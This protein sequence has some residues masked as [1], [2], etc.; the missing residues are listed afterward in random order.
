MRKIG[1]EMEE[2]LNGCAGERIRARGDRSRYAES[3]RESRRYPN[4]MTWDIVWWKS[5][6]RQQETIQGMLPNLNRNPVFKIEQ[7]GKRFDVGSFR[8]HRSPP[9]S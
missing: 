6:Q 8:F 1:N 3:C 5:A 4:H 7:V 9:T 2:R